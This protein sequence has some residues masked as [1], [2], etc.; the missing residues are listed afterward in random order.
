MAILALYT[1]NSPF[2]SFLLTLSTSRLTPDLTPITAGTYFPPTNRWGVTGFTTVLEKIAE[3]WQ[4]GPQDIIRNGNMILN[5]MKKTANINRVSESADISVDA[6]FAQLTN[7][8][9]QNIDDVWGGFGSSTKFPEVPKINLGFHAQIHRPDSDLARISL[10][11]LRNIANGGIHDHVFGGFCRYSVDRQWHIPHFEK[12]LYDQGQLLTAYTNAYKLT[13][14]KFFLDVADKIYTYIIQ[15]LHHPSGGFYCGED[16]DSYR[17]HGD[18]DK[19]EGAFYAWT[20]DEIQEIFAQNAPK[21]EGK[22]NAFEIYCYYY[23]ID[24]NGNVSPT[25]DPH[26]HLLDRNILRVRTTVHDA[27]LKFGTTADDVTNLLKIGNNL[28]YVERCK[29]PRPQLDTKIVT[30]WNGLM[31]SGLSI[32]STVQDSPRRAEYL[33]TARKLVD[34]I[35][36]HAYNPETKKLNRSCYGENVESD[37]VTY[38]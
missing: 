25:S 27:A 35:K 30:A 26:G 38:L 36:K 9:E 10:V 4:N 6:R 5:V 20:F 32:L 3:I 14:D 11:T 33:D 19:I 31:L 7:I 34:F 18:D 28:L 15:D 8:Y 2:L 12:M 21:F 24:E 22:S 13:G 16:A 37:A 1:R 29:R 17:Q 23:G